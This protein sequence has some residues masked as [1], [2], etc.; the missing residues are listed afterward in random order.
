MDLIEQHL[1]Q[2]TKVHTMIQAFMATLSKDMQT[3]DDN[4][5]MHTTSLEELA[6][7]RISTL[8]STGN[9]DNIHQGQ[10]SMNKTK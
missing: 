3:L 7:H 1:I 8:R 6:Y 9:L 10:E 5:A 4:I 2:P